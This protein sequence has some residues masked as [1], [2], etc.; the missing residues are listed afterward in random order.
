MLRS[1]K[2]KTSKVINA[3]QKKK[4]ALNFTLKEKLSLTATCSFSARL[5]N[6]SDSM[7]FKLLVNVRSVIVK[8]TVNSLSATNKNLIVIFPLR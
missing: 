2:R 8:K 7:S 5:R 1:A 3:I 6:S 4:F